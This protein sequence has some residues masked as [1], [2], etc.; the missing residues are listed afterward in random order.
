MTTPEGSEK[1]ISINPNQHADG[2][3]TGPAVVLVNR[4][5]LTPNAVAVDFEGN[6]WIASDALNRL[7]RVK[8]VGATNSSAT[9]E[10][11]IQVVTNNTVEN[12]LVGLSNLAI[13]VNADVAHGSIFITTPGV[14]PSYVG[15]DWT[16]GVALSWA[17]IVNLL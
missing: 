13:G 9:S 5:E 10:P 3:A 11:S 16:S 6:A 8:S 12:T 14:F 1:G 17:D 2:Q 15:K 7:T 4:I